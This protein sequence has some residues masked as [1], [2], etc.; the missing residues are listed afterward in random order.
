MQKS[1]HPEIVQSRGGVFFIMIAFF[2]KKISELES[3][4][5]FWALHTKGRSVSTIEKYKDCIKQFKKNI[6]D[7]KVAQIKKEDFEKI[8]LVLYEQK[9]S[10]ARIA[11]V[12]YT[13]RSFL[14]Y[15]KEEKGEDVLV[16]SEIKIPPREKGKEVRT[17]SDIEIEGMIKQLDL[18]YYHKGNRRI[19]HYNLHALRWRCLLLCLWSSGMRISEALS[20]DRTDVDL[21]NGEAIVMGKG[22][23]WRKVFFSD[24][25]IDAIKLYLSERHDNHE[26]LFVAHCEAQRWTL[27][28]AQCYLERL[29]EKG[30]LSKRFTFHVLR[31][32][33]AT[34]VY[35][36]SHDIHATS[37]LL[38]HSE[39]R[40]TVKH[41][42]REDWDEIKEVHNKAFRG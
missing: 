9:L 15:C 1:P 11:S 41:Y 6:G 40:T 22:K 10:V 39:E 23:K 36:K 28:S 8:K 31:R 33:F 2:S 13:M 32:S 42:I 38:G 3:S 17:L 25:A 19:K 4:F 12:L 18:F 27:S 21:A 30:K 16:L 24:L 35:R 34:H 20:L 37:K 29:R 5:Y 26:A 7:K 14:A